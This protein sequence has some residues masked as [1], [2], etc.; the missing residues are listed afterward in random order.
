[1]KYIQDN[2]GDASDGANAKAAVFYSISST[3]PGLQ[4]SGVDLGAILLKRAVSSLKAEFPST[5]D[6]FST[7][8][9]MPRFA[10]V[11]KEVALADCDRHG[12][13]EGDAIK[14]SSFLSPQSHLEGSAESEAEDVK[15]ALMRLAASYLLMHK[16]NRGG[17]LC[18]VGNFHV[19]NGARVGRI[20]WMADP[21]SWV[22]PKADRSW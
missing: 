6:E 16:N 9:L 22:T 12:I 14:I 19:R 21:Q 13:N 18:P 1:M 8:S 2:T 7:L 5:L 20:N 11:V 3:Q 4:G 10:S 15:P 17:I